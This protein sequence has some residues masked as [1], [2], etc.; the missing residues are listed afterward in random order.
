MAV[1]RE[2]F[3]GYYERIKLRSL[4]RG[5]EASQQAASNMMAAAAYVCV[6]IPRTFPHVSIAF[7]ATFLATSLRVQHK[8][9]DANLRGIFDEMWSLHYV[10]RWIMCYPGWET[11]ML[12]NFGLCQIV[13]HLAVQQRSLSKYKSPVCGILP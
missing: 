5:L 2:N 10:I 11:D 1:A 7:T 6:S 12:Q 4:K 8:R 9:L 3:N 13:P